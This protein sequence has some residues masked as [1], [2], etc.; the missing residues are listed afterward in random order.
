MFPGRYFDHHLIS[1]VLFSSQTC[2][3]NHFYFVFFVFLG[4]AH[5][6]TGLAE[7]GRAHV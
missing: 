5:I 2:K 7:I 3:A 4:Q 6:L 1:L